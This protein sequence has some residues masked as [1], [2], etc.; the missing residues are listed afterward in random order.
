[1]FNAINFPYYFNF[2][3][4]QTYIIAGTGSGVTEGIL[5][6]P[7]ERVKIS[8]QSLRSHMKDVSKAIININ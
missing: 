6:T 4:F 7:F 5:I 8:L 2:F 3:Y 1:M